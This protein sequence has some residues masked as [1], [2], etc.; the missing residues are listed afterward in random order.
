[1]KPALAAS[2]EFR[3]EKGIEVPTIRRTSVYPLADMEPG[4]SFF[5]P[6]ESV[7]D[8]SAAAARLWGRRNDRKFVSRSVDGGVRIWRLA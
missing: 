3:I 7:R 1:M 4:D 8:R 6:G 5:V 2:N